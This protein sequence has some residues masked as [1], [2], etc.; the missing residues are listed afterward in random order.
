MQLRTAIKE[1][2][3][4]VTSVK[5]WEVLTKATLSQI[6]VPAASVPLPPVPGAPTLP[7]LP[8]TAY[9]VVGGGSSEQFVDVEVPLG[10]VVSIKLMFQRL[11]SS[12]SGRLCGEQIAKWLETKGADVTQSS[13]KYMIDIADHNG[14]GVLDFWEFLGMQL[15]LSMGLYRQGVVLVE[16]MGF[17][18]G[19]QTVSPYIPSA[20][21][22]LPPLT[23]YP[24]AGAAYGSP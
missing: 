13:V 23:P 14:D 18:A 5:K 15:Y 12:G 17:V 22:V 16:W 24:P 11:D 19:R 10:L 1:Q 20:P 3:A 8:A 6:L 9:S 2:T 4:W 21:T 7:P